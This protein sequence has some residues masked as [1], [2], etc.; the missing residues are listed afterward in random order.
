MTVGH[1]LSGLARA[2]RPALDF[3]ALIRL[4]RMPLIQPFRNTVDRRAHRLEAVQHV[5]LTVDGLEPLRPGLHVLRHDSGALNS[6]IHKRGD[7]SIKL[8][9][10][11]LQ[12]RHNA[13]RLIQPSFI[14][15]NEGH[16]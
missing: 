2:T 11:D 12:E 4:V 16:D 13:S 8:G 7:D 9:G 5:A 1:A 3:S 15:L 10:D 6:G 14:L